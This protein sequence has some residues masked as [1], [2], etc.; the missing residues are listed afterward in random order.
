MYVFAKYTMALCKYA[1]TVRHVM[2][3]E[4]IASRRMQIHCHCDNSQM[5]NTVL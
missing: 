4:S 1:Y 2:Y 3:R 5:F